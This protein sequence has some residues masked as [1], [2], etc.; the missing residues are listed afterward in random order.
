MVNYIRIIAILFSVLSCTPEGQWK[1]VKVTAVP[2]INQ[3]I[4]IEEFGLKLVFINKGEFNSYSLHNKKVVNIKYPFWIDRYEMTNQLYC[5]IMKLKTNPTEQ[6]LAVDLVSW[7][8]ANQFCKKLNKLCEKY[9]PKGYEFRLPTELE[10]EYACQAGFN[11]DYNVEGEY[12]SFAW[13]SKNSKMQVNEPGLLRPNS[14]G[15]YDMHGNVGEWCLDSYQLDNKLSFIESS[16]FVTDKHFMKSTRGGSYL[17]D[18]DKAT[19]SSRF[20]WYKFSTNP[21]Y[22]FRIVLAPIIP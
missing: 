13:H 10:W 15:I 19:S 9:I 18:I 7:E 11:S 12:D 21:G 4:E 6:R 17:A 22:G 5:K 14:W 8:D 20:G 16:Y 2:D 3:N 1:S